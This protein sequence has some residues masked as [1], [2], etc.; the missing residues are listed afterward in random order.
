VRARGVHSSRLG[1]SELA[2]RSITLQLSAP[3]CTPTPPLTLNTQGSASPLN[4]ATQRA[5]A[6]PGTGPQGSAEQQADH[7][8]VRVQQGGRGW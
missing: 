6:H 1:A 2:L 3:D 5:Q 4:P 8:V 7:L